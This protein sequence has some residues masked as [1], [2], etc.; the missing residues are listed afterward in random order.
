MKYLAFGCS[1]GKL[2]KIN[3]KDFDAILYLGDLAGDPIS[4]E[5]TRGYISLLANGYIEKSFK[6][7]MGRSPANLEIR[8]KQNARRIARYLN[9]LDKEVYILP[10]NWDSYRTRFW[11]IK[12]D[13]YK[14]YIIKN[15]KN[16]KDLH[17]KFVEN[18]EHIIIGYGIYEHPEKGEKEFY[19]YH[20]KK[21][22]VLFEKA[23]KKKKPVIFIT[24]NQPYNTKFSFIR[25][26]RSI[27]DG[28]QVGSNVIK[29]IIKEFKPLLSIGAHMHEHFGK[30]KIGKTTCIAAG[31]GL[32][33]KKVLIDVGNK[34]K[35]IKFIRK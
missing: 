15:L 4:R 3:T 10:G 21:L 22:R 8:E 19:E 2:P 5:L 6:K 35:S 12:R 17:L 30:L 34:I 25:D 29:D 33:G 13:Y 32:E 11:N 14:A 28:M 16:L 7:L 1:H 24:H 20:L 31:Y 9:S 18:K 23:K 26:K 27:L